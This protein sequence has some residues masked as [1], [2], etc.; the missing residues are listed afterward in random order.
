MTY[1]IYAKKIKIN[2]NFL[3]KKKDKLFS[4]FYFKEWEIR[5]IY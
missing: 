5:V 3:S 2:L 1:K 4:D